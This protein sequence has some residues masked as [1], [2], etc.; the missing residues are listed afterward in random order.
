MLIFYKNYSETEIR[1]LWLQEILKGSLLN[2][3][4]GKHSK[5]H[6]IVN[7]LEYNELQLTKN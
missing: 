7:A 3:M 6:E 4:C 2:I 5:N 1:M